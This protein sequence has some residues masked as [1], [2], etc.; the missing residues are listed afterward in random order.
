MWVKSECAVN[1]EYLSHH[2]ALR[3]VKSSSSRR[4]EM[5]FQKVVSRQML[6]ESLKSKVESVVDIYVIKRIIIIIII[7]II[8]SSSSSRAAA[9][10]SSSMASITNTRPSVPSL[11]RS[12]TLES[13]LTQTAQ[14]HLSTQSV[15]INSLVLPFCHYTSPPAYYE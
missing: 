13:F 14:N 11:Y 2:F 7:I 8:S 3:N 15:T 12:A 9:A 5:S 4:W 6:R 1:W 10:T